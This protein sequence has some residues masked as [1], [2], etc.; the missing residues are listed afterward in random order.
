[1]IVWVKILCEGGKSNLWSWGICYV[2]GLVFISSLLCSLVLPL[3]PFFCLFPLLCFYI[4]L[5]L[6]SFAF[7]FKKTVCSWP[8]SFFLILLCF[9][10]V[11]CPLSF[12]F[13]ALMLEK[14][15]RSDAVWK[16]P[17]DG[18]A[19]NRTVPLRPWEVSYFLPNPHCRE[20]IE[21]QY[22]C[23]VLALISFLSSHQPCDMFH[24]GLIFLNCGRPNICES[25]NLDYFSLL[26]DHQHYFLFLLKHYKGWPHLLLQRQIYFVFFRATI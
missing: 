11:A 10:T 17:F 22:S 5:S 18:R 3:L 14:T 23:K 25:I 26:D 9:M 15:Q 4:A 1:M 8:N 13:I 21:T 24:F 19:S 2:F 12:F 7:L 6:S 16:F 20:N